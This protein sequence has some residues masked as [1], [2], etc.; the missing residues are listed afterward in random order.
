MS[1]LPLK[2]SPENTD[3]F[4]EW[5]F[6]THGGTDNASWEDDECDEVVEDDYSEN[7]EE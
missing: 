2:V 4:S 1:Q 5:Y 7:D 6:E 3:A